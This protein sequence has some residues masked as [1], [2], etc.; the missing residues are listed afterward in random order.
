MSAS[1]K[2]LQWFND[3]SIASKI[4]AITLF[5]FLV[6]FALCG[7]ALSSLL[8]SRL[9]QSA[10]ENLKQGNHRIVQMIDAYGT[11]LERS[12]EML[13]AVIALRIAE[14]LQTE[15]G[16]AGD[17]VGEGVVEGAEA[18]QQGFEK[19]VE[20]FTAATGNVASIFVR[21]GDDFVRTATTLKDAQGNKVL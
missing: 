3:R 2:P 11:G 16:V 1:L 6:V 19:E 13:G 7:A 9:E 20:A 10:T 15:A 5:V 4:N 12:A 21:Q 18:A 17:S 14:V 8:S